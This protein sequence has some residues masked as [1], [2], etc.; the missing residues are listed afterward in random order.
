MPFPVKV[1]LMD[2]NEKVKPGM[3]AEATLT[4]A[5]ENQ[6]PGYTVPLQAILP[7]AE[8]NRGLPLCMTPRHRRSK[9]RRSCFSGVQGK[10]AVATEGLAPGTLL[11]WPV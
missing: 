4:I 2:P 5:K 1:E 7:A 6:A 10:K 11:P 9:K 3:T 8:T